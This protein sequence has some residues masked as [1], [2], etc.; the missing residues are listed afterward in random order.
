MNPKSSGLRA[1]PVLA[2]LVAVVL[3]VAAGYVYWAQHPAPQVEFT[4]L[5]GE[6]SS[7]QA[8][9]GKVVYVV[10]WATSCATCI[11]EM[12]D[13]IKT[14]E[15]FAQSNFEL[16]AVAM[17]YDPPEYVRNYTQQKNLPFKVVL[18]STGAGAIAK[19]FG[20]VQ[21]TPT[22]FLVDKQGM[23]LSRTVGEP[24]FGALRATIAREL[25]K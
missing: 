25:V 8:Q 24:D 2:A 18:D 19:A 21:L 9:R 16:L 7:L 23:I 5:D 17:E 22:A 6:H 13:L 1:G 10:F 3:A 11:K 4:T 12:P 20:N 15:Q 14:H